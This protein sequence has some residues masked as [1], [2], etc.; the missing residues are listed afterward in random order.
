MLAT[1]V[2]SQCKCSRFVCSGGGVLMEVLNCSINC[3]SQQ[4]ESKKLSSYNVDAHHSMMDVGLD[5]FKL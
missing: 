5:I 4:R 3:A 1:R 2:R